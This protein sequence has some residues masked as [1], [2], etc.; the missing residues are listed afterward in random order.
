ML[1]TPLA[2]TILAALGVFV[3]ILRF[4]TAA[5]SQCDKLV[6][7][8]QE[9]RAHQLNR[10]R[11][12][13]P[14]ARRLRKEKILWLHRR[15]V[16]LETGNAPLLAAC[17]TRIQQIIATQKALDIQQRAI[18]AAA[19]QEARLSARQG[20]TKFEPY[21]ASVDAGQL[22]VRAKPPLDLA[23]EY[24]PIPDYFHRQAVAAKY[25]AKLKQ[26]SDLQL[27]DL[28]DSKLSESRLEHHCAATIVQRSD[29]KFQ[30]EMIDEK[31]I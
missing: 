25:L 16:A 1:L 2:L 13:N 29:E 31:A 22:L 11:Q 27:L 12:L 18:I 6:F 5:A 17:T 4:E 21:R 23:P 24:E 10:L 28:L 9:E 14:S 15:A 19:D 8:L 20:Q 3:M 7:Q 26:L 30:A